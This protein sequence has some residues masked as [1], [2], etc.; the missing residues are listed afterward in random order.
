MYYHDLKKIKSLLIL[1]T[2]PRRFLLKRC[3]RKF[4]N[5][6]RKTP[7]SEFLFN[8]VTDRRPVTLLKRDSGTGVF[9]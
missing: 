2:V 6:N 9:M 1:E 4:G 8:K 7:V 3:S 5:I